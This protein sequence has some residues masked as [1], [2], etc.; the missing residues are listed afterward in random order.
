M[1]EVRV[2]IETFAGAKPLGEVFYNVSA[3]LGT[4]KCEILVAGL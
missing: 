1:D 2:P 3:S 4:E